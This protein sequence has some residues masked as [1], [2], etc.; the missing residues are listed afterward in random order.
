MFK[1]TGGKALLRLALTGLMLAF[2]GSARSETLVAS[3]LHTRLV[4]GFKVA[5]AP[6][7][8]W[9]P[10]GWQ[11]NPPSAGPN[12]GANLIL[13]F[14]DRLLNLDPTGKPIGGGRDRYLALVVPAKQSTGTQTGNIVIRVY[15]E[16]TQLLPGAYKTSVL[17]K[18]LREHTESGHGVDLGVATDTWDVQDNAGGAIHLRVQYRRGTLARSTTE[19]KFFSPV[20]PDFFRIYRT[21]QG[22]DVVRSIP[23]GVD[24]VEDIEFKVS[25][26]ELT[27]IFDGTEQL[28]SVSESPWS[29]RDIFLPQ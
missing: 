21:Q 16:N 20:Q 19:A 4:V 13:G 12:R 6:V 8:R 7:Q 1:S 14:V 10:A 22:L 29:M 24:R 23:L 25:L 5:D 27:D 3:D 11:L 17:V 9:L 15:T 28:L 26:G 18:V 2:L